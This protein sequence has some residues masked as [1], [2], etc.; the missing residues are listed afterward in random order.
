MVA[1]LD[2]LYPG[3]DDSTDPDALRR[4]LA[5]LGLIGEDDQDDDGEDGAD[6]YDHAVNAAFALAERRTGV[7][8]EPG[9]VNGEL[10]YRAPI[11]RYYGSPGSARPAWA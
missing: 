9:H 2:P 10:P 3:W 7:R 6:R 8:L 1:R 11:A 4:D 5:D